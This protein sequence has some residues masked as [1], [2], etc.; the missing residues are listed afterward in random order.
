MAIPHS[1]GLTGVRS[2]SLVNRPHNVNS[3]CHITEVFYLKHFMRKL[4]LL[5]PSSLSRVNLI[6]HDLEES[7]VQWCISLGEEWNE[8][9]VAV[10]ACDFIR[11]SWLTQLWGLAKPAGGP[12]GR[13]WGEGICANPPPSALPPPTADWSRSSG[14]AEAA[15]ITF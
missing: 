12:R 11:R 2:S 3:C 6:Y 5:L 9:Q 8:Q 10:C 7:W 1:S 15:F 13:P 14:K 4:L